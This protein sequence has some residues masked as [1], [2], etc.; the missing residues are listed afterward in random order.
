MREDKPRKTKGNEGSGKDWSLPASA[1]T[2]GYSLEQ[3][4][5]KIFLTTLSCPIFSSP[6]FHA[7]LAVLLL[8]DTKLCQCP[9]HYLGH[10]VRTIILEGASEHYT[11][12]QKTVHNLCPAESI[13]STPT[14][15]V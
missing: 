14:E 9:R 5:W 10:L 11:C 13:A 3:S 6:P 4:Q 8:S 2:M 1:A 7:F 15:Q 12:S